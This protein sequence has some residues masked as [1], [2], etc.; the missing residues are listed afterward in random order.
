MHT[1]KEHMFVTHPDV[2]A[3][4]EETNLDILKQYK[5]KKRYIFS[6]LKLSRLHKSTVQLIQSGL[7]LATRNG[8]ETGSLWK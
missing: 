3:R 5:R 2:T 7:R 8:K 6:N 4:L 1:D